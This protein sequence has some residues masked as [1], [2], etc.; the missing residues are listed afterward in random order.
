MLALPAIVGAESGARLEA[1]PNYAGENMLCK[2]FVLLF[3]L[4]GVGLMLDSGP[5]V[6][7]NHDAST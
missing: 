7:I 1:G 5:I 4:L 2:I 3:N 6:R